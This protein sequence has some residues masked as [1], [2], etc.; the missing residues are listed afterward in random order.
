M[1]SFHRPGPRVHRNLSRYLGRW[2]GFHTCCN[3]A[4]YL[5]QVYIFISPP[6]RA[7][8]IYLFLWY[9]VDC[10]PKRRDGRFTLT[11]CIK[12]GR[13]GKQ[14]NKNGANVSSLCMFDKFDVSARGYRTESLFI[15]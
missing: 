2:D 5:A 3:P 15:R 7:R 13:K 1:K 4:I 9:T 8:A 12:E 10:D 11:V 14:N 6:G